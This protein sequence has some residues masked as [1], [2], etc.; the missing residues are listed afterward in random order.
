M[1]FND[2]QKFYKGKKI[3]LTGHTGFKGSWLALWLS[4]MGA[5]VVGYALK[6]DE[7]SLFNL[8]KVED[9]LEKSIIADIRNE[10]E[11]GN[12]VKEFQP[13]III[14]MA[15]Q[16]LVRR[17]YVDPKE[18]YETN[19]I[20]T[21]NLFEAARK[22]GSVKAVLNITTDKCYE[23]K[24]ID[25]AY[26]EEDPM[27]GYDPYS[28]SKACAEILTSS[29][30]RSFF[31]KEGIHLASARAGNVIGGGDFSC[32]RI[33]PDI[34]RSIKDKKEVQLRSPNAIRPWQHV[35]EPL[36]GYLILTKNLYEKGEF[37][38]KAY[39]F[40]PD[41]DAEVNVENLTKSLIKNLQLGS[42]K[43][44]ENCNLHEAGILKLDNSKAKEELNFYPVLNFDNA[45][46]MTAEWYLKYLEN[47][48]LV[49][50]FTKKQ[51]EE[52]CNLCRHCYYL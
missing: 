12:A 33:I 52:F 26:R 39:N 47:R 16:P 36:H 34:V 14:H 51:I 13:E 17:S 10:I 38:A 46:K 49:G 11:L 43:I 45:I 1:S 15:A 24:E 8:G 23:N 42:Y 27:G 2:L 30:R 7:E 9:G 50:D 32:D 22:S 18:T 35:L 4:Q 29:Y 44:S 19:I 21:L 5:K 25:Y 20:G 37:F 48:D 28:S 3:F 31:T 40:G 6:A 41:K